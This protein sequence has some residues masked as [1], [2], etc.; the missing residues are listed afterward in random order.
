[1]KKPDWMDLENLILV[2]GHAIYV[3]EKFD[4]PTSDRSWCLEDFQKGEPP[5]YIEH[6]RHGVEL[7]AEDRKA[8]L[9]F[10]GG[11]TRYKAGP[12]SEAQSYWMVAN[13]FDWW[14]ATGACLRTSTEEFARDSFENLLFGICRFFECV[15]NYPKE[16]RVVSWAFKQSRFN[17]HREAINF[18]KSRFRFEGFNNPED[19]LSATS[20]EEKN[21]I[22]P[23]KRDPYGTEESSLSRSSKDTGT[24]L[25]D[26]RKERNPFNRQHSYELSCHDLA[27]LLRHRGPQHYGGALPWNND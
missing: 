21:A 15:R 9:L 14:G 12:I 23:F 20:G 5:L 26:K 4:D 1:M 17:L 2:A 11:Q 27:K 19:L 22:I 24:H 6:I 8:L 13:H 25:G 3:G 10:S 7:A 16:I 18:P